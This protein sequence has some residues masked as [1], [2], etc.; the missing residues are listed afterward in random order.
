MYIIR[1]LALVVLTLEVKFFNSKKFRDSIFNPTRKVKDNPKISVWHNN[2]SFVARCLAKS[3]LFTSV[4]ITGIK[5]L[6]TL[7]KSKHSLLAIA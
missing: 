3:H 5:I 1:L 4:L 6:L 2:L 7:Q